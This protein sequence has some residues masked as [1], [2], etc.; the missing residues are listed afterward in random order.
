MVEFANFPSSCGL[1]EECIRYLLSH[2]FSKP[3]GNSR[4]T[5][6]CGTWMARLVVVHWPEPSTSVSDRHLGDFIEERL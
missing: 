2:V 6:A 5:H 1:Q 3:G 4:T